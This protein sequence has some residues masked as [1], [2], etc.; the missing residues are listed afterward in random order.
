MINKVLLVLTVASMLASFAG[1][2]GGDYDGAF[3][4]LLISFWTL[5]YLREAAKP[6]VIY[7]SLAAH[8]D[9]LICNVKPT[10]TPFIRSAGVK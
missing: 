5:M 4:H 10:D 9:D 2:V 8:L 6:K 1:M 7:S 3:H